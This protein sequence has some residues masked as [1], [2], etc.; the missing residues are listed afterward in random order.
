MAVVQMTPKHN[1]WLI[2]PLLAQVPDFYPA[3]VPKHAG[4]VIDSF[5]SH[6]P[7]VF[8]GTFSG[9]YIYIWGPQQKALER[10]MIMHQKVIEGF[11]ASDGNGIDMPCQATTVSIS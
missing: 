11:L 10:I 7:G 9:T 6:S 5:R 8:S 2:L 1:Q 3:D 4:A